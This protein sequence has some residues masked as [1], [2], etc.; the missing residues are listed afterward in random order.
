LQLSLKQ[1]SSVCQL[2]ALVPISIQTIVAIMISWDHT[3]E[4]VV[5]P[6]LQLKPENFHRI[7]CGRPKRERRD[8]SR[9]SGLPTLSRGSVYRKLGL[10]CPRY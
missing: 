1:V 4:I 7:T 10:N 8:L 2:Y 6:V 5:C 9:S 3:A